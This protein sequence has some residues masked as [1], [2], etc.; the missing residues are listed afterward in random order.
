MNN[1]KIRSSLMEAGMKNYQ[2]AELMGVSEFTLSRRLRTELPAE[3]QERILSL[4]KERMKSNA[5]NVT[6]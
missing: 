2:L 5:H 6:N 4:I 1:I 3:E